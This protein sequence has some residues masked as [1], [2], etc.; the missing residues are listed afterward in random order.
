MEPNT[1]VILIWHCNAGSVIVTCLSFYLS[2]LP[3]LKK[4]ILEAKEKKYPDTSLLKRMQKVVNEAEQCANLANQLVSRNSKQPLGSA[5]NVGNKKTKL[6]ISELEQFLTQ[7][8][9][10]PCII[11]ESALVRV[12]IVRLSIYSRFLLLNTK[13][14]SYCS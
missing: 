7:I 5:E 3:E 1:V 10:L 11:Q 2:A 8:N 6:S 13:G 4:L 12:G 9:E 14:N